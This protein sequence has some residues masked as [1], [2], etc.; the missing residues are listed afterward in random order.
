MVWRT[1]WS[2]S[3]SNSEVAWIAVSFAK[4]QRRFWISPGSLLRRV[5]DWA[6]MI[7]GEVEVMWCGGF[8]AS[9]LPSRTLDKVRLQ[10]LMRMGCA[11]GLVKLLSCGYGL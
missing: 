9:A 5:K 2:R 1:F 8:V 7:S 10:C 3:L 11:K 4:A 6:A